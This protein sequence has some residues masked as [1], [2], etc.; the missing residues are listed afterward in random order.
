[1]SSDYE[2]SLHLQNLSKKPGNTREEVT[3]NIVTGFSHI[4]W[5]GIIQ[6]IRHQHESQG[7]L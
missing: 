2:F 4:Q 6:G 1:M 3:A 5:E 7:S